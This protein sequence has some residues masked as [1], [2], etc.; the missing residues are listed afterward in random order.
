MKVIIPDRSDGV[1][2]ANM[3]SIY[4]L[5]RPSLLHSKKPNTKLSVHLY[6]G[7]IHAKVIVIDR[8]TA[9]LGSANLT[10]G[11]FDLLSETNAIFRQTDGVVRDL[12]TQME[13]DLTYCTKLSLD[14]IP[15]YKKWMAWIQKIFI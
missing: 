11:S 8:C 9:I 1:Y 15:P 2:H 5:L 3:Y 13:E 14:T 7:H 4:Q 10:Y 12:I 6:P